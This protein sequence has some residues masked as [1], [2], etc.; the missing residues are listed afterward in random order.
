MTHITWLLAI[1]LA[2]CFVLFS[3]FAFVLV[4]H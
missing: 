2:L 3:A 4:G 1:S